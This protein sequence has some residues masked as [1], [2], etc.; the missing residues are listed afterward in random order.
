MQTTADVVAVLDSSFRQIFPDARPIKAT[1]KEEAK[2]MQ[3]P[4]ESGAS[5]VDHRVILPVEIKLSL[6]IPGDAYRDVYQQIR[7]YWLRGD[8]L[9]VQ[10]LAGTYQNMMISG[11]PHDE[12]SDLIDALPMEITLVEQKIASTKFSGG[13]S[14][15]GANGD[16]SVPRDSP[17][18]GRGQQQGTT[19][20]TG[21][22]GK[23]GSTIYDIIF[24]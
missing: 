13:A 21:Q 19:P 3:H 16:P 2:A 24:S 14:K 15:G 18:T 10:T 4:V 22:Q 8:L 7:Q 20:S 9:T 12:S 5:V 6:I 11:M 1:V 17:T 23:A